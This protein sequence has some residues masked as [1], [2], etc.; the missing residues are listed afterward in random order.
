MVEQFR[1]LGTTI[2]NQNSVNAELRPRSKKECLLS[3]SA[4]SCTFQIATQKLKLKIIRTII[5][6]LI[7]YG[8]EILLSHRGRNIG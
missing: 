7:L 1:Y 4:E 5:L 3:F 2:T 8:C 6:L